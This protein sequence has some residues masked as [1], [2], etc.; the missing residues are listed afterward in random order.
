VCVQ[1]NDLVQLLLRRG[2][3]ID[4]VLPL[5]T[6]CSSVT[7]LM[8]C[9]VPAVVKQLLAAGADVHA[10][11]SKGYTCLHTAVIHDHPTPVLC[12]LIKAGANLAAVDRQGLTAAD[13]AHIK[14]S[15]L[16]A[17]L[18]VRAAKDVRP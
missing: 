5:S 11:S 18:L 6:V 9:R 8:V 10:V 15:H 7:V 14:G 2:A 4:R 16:T 3:A 13:I 17:A 12:L 1:S